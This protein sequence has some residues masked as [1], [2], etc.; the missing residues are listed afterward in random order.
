MAKAQ[1]SNYAKSDWVIGKVIRDKAKKL[2][3]KVFVRTRE[4]QLTYHEMNSISDKFS[5]GF[6]NLGLGKGDKVCLMLDNCLEHLYC[7]FAL[8]KIGA[9]DVPIN[10]AYK[11]QILSYIINNSEAKA[12]VIAQH[13]L[14]RIKFLEKDLKK[15]KNVIVHVPSGSDKIELELTLETFH[16]KEFY[17]FSD[18]IPDVKVHYSDLATIIYTSGTTGPSKGVMMSHAFNYSFAQVTLDNIGLTYDDI[19]YTCLPL[20]HANAR[21]LCIYPCLLAEAQAAMAPRFSLSGFWNDIRHFNATVFNGLGAIGPLLFSAPPK[22]DD[23]NNPARLALLI[24]TP[25]PYKEFENRFGLKV[26][27]SYGLTEINLPTFPS[28]DEEM[29]EGTCGKV[30]PGFEIRIVN[31]YDEEC[32]D[33]EVGELIIRHSDPFTM[34]SGYYNMPDKTAEAYRNL[35]FHTGDA[36]YRDRDGWYYFVDRIKDAVRRRGENI[37]SFEVENVINSHPAVLECAVIAVKNPELTEDEV[38]V[39]LVLD[40]G[41]ELTPEELIK[42]CEPRMPYFHV[43]R[44]IEIMDSLPKTSTDKI[45]KIELRERGLTETTWDCEKAGIKIKR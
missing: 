4:T 26:T 37:S 14:D 42:F 40:K 45:R 28:L 16:L 33:G 41:E 43:P 19:D 18:T 29:P 20:F 6:M 10:T 31:E 1:V 36:L 12:I 27:T 30:I 38:K 34:L 25:K 13:Y 21:L 3:E 23:H 44:Y 8:G 2:Q 32:P 11:G 17:S 24:P 22:D 35:W 7:W 9:V 5:N 15:L 39:C